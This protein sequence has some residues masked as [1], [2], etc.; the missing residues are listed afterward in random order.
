VS[1]ANSINASKN[2]GSFLFMGY[3][4]PT[5]SAPTGST[6][7]LTQNIEAA[8]YNNTLNVVFMFTIPV[9]SANYVTW[10]ATDGTGLG[11]IGGC[12][13]TIS[14]TAGQYP[15]ML[16]MMVMA[17][18]NYNA[19]N[20]V[21][22]YEFQQSSSL[23][24]SVTSQTV[25]NALNAASVNYYGQTQ[26]AGVFLNFYQQGVLLGIASDPLDM[27]VYANEVWLKDAVA[28]ALMN[29]LIGLPVLSANAQGRGQI[30]TTLQTPVN[31][32]LL[33]GTISV[34]KPLTTTQIQYITLQSGSANAWYQ[35]QNGGYWLNAAIIPDPNNAG[36]YIA[37][38]TLIYSKDDVIRLVNGTNSLI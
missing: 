31:R 19:V 29:L 12:G 16:P 13:L 32:A 37:T 9:T 25:A 34:G 36:K 11:L 38:Y 28:A 2:F 24:A 10:S 1:V 6:L 20:S 17:S 18:T 22:N 5:S 7:T 35:V 14:N 30:L 8:N 33:N 21:Q 26:T 15:E 4:A 23:T 3:L 27:N